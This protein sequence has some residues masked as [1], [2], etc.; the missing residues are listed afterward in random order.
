MII[1]IAV[2][3]VCANCGKQLEVVSRR[4][5]SEGVVMIVRHRGTRECP[6][7]GTR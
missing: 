6:G 4:D 3:A 1:A 2:S 7:T 5:Y